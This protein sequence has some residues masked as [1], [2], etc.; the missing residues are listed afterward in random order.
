MTVL[1]FASLMAC[2]GG[3]T[4]SSV[5]GA[6][7]DCHP[8]DA[9]R[10]DHPRGDQVGS[11]IPAPVP[12]RTCTL[13]QRGC[14]DARQQGILYPPA[15]GIVVS[16]VT[17][18][19]IEVTYDLGSDLDDCEPNELRVTVDTTISQLP[20][21]GDDFPVTDQRGTL[22]IE[23]R[24]LPGNVDYGPPDILAV[25]STTADGRRSD[26]A[27]VALP[28]A[29]GE[30]RLSATQR[31]RI[32]AHF[33]AC[34]AVIGARTNCQMGAMH[35]VSG[36][37]AGTTADFTRSV[38]L[39]LERTSGAGFE[40]T[41]LRC[42]DNTRCDATF[43]TGSGRLD[44]SYRMAALKSVP[45]CWELTAFSVTRPIPELDNIAAPLPSSGC[46]DR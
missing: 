17:T 21:F 12:R 6:A 36:P 23:R 2:G 15:P 43:S 25:S 34:R 40:L 8:A 26:S 24:E 10:P 45:T 30:R 1:A 7:F 9:N 33:E 28:P 3:E 11:V 44:M 31:Q 20:P 35:P 4:S 41:R 46:T 19:A 22:R 14:L 42:F 27:R 32:N 39:Y 38:R 18:T 5:D 29:D 16:S 37:V 13:P